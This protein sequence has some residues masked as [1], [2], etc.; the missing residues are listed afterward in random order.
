VL[1]GVP[2]EPNG[3]HTVAI[4]WDGGAYDNK[5]NVGIHANDDKVKGEEVFSWCN[6]KATADVHCVL[7]FLRLKL[8]GTRKW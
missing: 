3:K 1:N 5:R 6:D 8:N 7:P 4:A 2:V